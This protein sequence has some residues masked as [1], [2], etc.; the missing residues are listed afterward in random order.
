MESLWQQQSEQTCRLGRV[1]GS[2]IY[3]SKRKPAPAS[4]PRRPTLLT[5]PFWLLCFRGWHSEVYRLNCVVLYCSALENEC[6]RRGKWT[7]GS[8][9]SESWYVMWGCRAPFTCCNT[10]TLWMETARS[11]RPDCLPRTCQRGFRQQDQMLQ[12]PQ[13]WWALF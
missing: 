8:G 2:V 10:L 6:N 9:F 13:A 3:T 4:H 7:L 12:L 11:H 1:K 5:C